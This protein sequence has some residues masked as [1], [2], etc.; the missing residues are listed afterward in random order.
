MPS[1]PLY[2]AP[3]GAAERR[4]YAGFMAQAFAGSIE[5]FEPW[6]HGYGEDVRLLRPGP[7]GEPQAGLVIYDMAQY[8]GGA[9]VPCWGIAGV[10]VRAEAR[11]KGYARELMRHNLREQFENGSPIAALYP[12]AP[13]LYRNLGWEFAGTRCSYKYRLSELPAG[14]SELGL[15]PVTEGDAEL[16]VRLY[17]RRYGQENGCLD[18]GEKIW[19]RI[20]RTPS[21]SPLCGYIAERDGEP[22]GYVLYIQKREGGGMRFDLF[23]R[24]LVCLTRDA[25]QAL[26]AFFARHRSVA[27]HLHFYAAPGDPLLIELQRTH[28]VPIEERLVWMLRIVRVRDALEAR[29]YSPHVTAAAEV[30]VLDSEL[31]DN[32]GTWKLELAD[33]R[34]K[35]ERGGSA[36][37]RLEVRGLAMLYAG[38]CTTQQ[39]R[40]AGLLTGSE[41]GDVALAAMFAGPAA[42]MPDFF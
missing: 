16:I 7:S 6:V 23:A 35:V 1:L 21:E 5:A 41:D 33:G 34:M 24:D 2:G 3:D 29:G 10:V 26:M 12:A 14:P 17:A 18:R 40:S 13:K 37:A 20:R 22:E 42:W 25:A 15:R 19:E 8:F 30:E 28:H 36:K 38:G 27:D 31:P 9:S 4:L 11:A 32:A 39:L